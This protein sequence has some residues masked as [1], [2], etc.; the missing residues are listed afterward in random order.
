MPML[1]IVALAALS[2][3]ATEGRRLGDE[4]IPDM[5][6][7]MQ[8]PE[9]WDTFAAADVD[10]PEDDVHGAVLYQTGD[11]GEASDD[12]DSRETILGK[13]EQHGKGKPPK[14]GA[15]G[16]MDFDDS[17]MADPAKPKA[18]MSAAGNKA[19]DS[20]A[21]DDGEKPEPLTAGQATLLDFQVLEF[22][23]Q[24]KK[25]EKA[26]KKNGKTGLTKGGA[27][28]LWEQVKA[29]KKE[30]KEDVDEDAAA[31]GVVPKKD[32]QKLLE[33]LSSFQEELEDIGLKTG[34]KAVAKPADALE[35]EDSAEVP[36]G[37]DVLKKI[38][39]EVKG[40]RN[41]I[42][43]LGGKLGVSGSKIGPAQE[44]ERNIR[45]EVDE[46][47]DDAGGAAGAGGDK[48]EPDLD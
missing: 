16:D 32:G 1:R 24:L 13:G 36:V 17:D 46:D 25:L 48:S 18:E 39:G 15:V 2:G 20:S 30:V 34:V 21:D 27:R 10:G 26:G 47:D 5:N 19:A 23:D 8:E 40:F 4:P 33:E 7:G 29:F 41:E 9:D 14:K 11:A 28:S 12:E 35:E 42:E 37:M 31:G 45:N 38:E 22:E 43:E 44:A 3:V 6:P